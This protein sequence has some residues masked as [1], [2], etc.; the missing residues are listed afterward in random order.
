MKS[1]LKLCVL[2][3]VLILLISCGND[4]STGPDPDPDPGPDPNPTTNVV[5]KEI[6]PDGGEITSADG[7]L[8]LTF[9]S[10]AL[11]NEETITI[12]PLEADSLGSEFDDIGV[13]IAYGLGRMVWNLIFQLQ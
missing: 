3:L 11:A 2:F 6:G 5:S 8:T 9:P 10:G 13:E 7:L 1:Q 4:N 12:A